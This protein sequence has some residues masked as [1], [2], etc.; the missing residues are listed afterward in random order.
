MSTKDNTG[1]DE[2]DSTTYDEESIE[3]ES[4]H[5]DRVS[6][7]VGA[8]N[9]DEFESWNRERQYSENI[10]NG[11]PYYNSPGYISP[12]K[13]HSPS[14]L[15]QCHRKLFYDNQ[16]TPS[17][18]GMPT[19]VFFFGNKFEDEMALPFLEDTANDLHSNNYIRQDMYINY[20]VEVDD[21]ELL[22]KGETDPVIADTE[23]APLVV[24]EIKTTG[25]IDNKKGEDATPS[26]RHKAQLH[27]Y[28]A[29][30]DKQYDREIEKGIIVYAERD[31]LEMVVFEIDFDEDFWEKTV[32]DWAT[33][34]T[35]FRLD[36]E[37]PP[38][39]PEEPSW[40]CKYC[41]YRERCGQNNDNEWEDTGINGFVPLVEYPDTEVVDYIDSEADNNAKLTP[42]LAYQHPDL[43]D[44]YDVFDW[45]CDHCDSSFDWNHFDWDGDNMNPP[46]CPDCADEHGNLPLRGPV[47]AEQLSK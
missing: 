1:A 25:Y 40:E 47:P 21:V 9:P 18:S 43:T 37:L 6:D 41:D 42:T 22:I 11:K 3:T 35:E 27:A 10:K 34:Q 19:G 36:D 31:S 29:G 20:E 23:G 46:T 14:K 39:D 7:I 4:E 17:E 33:D 16:N 13:K 28:M 44:D 38:A 32:L 5:N 26:R 30:L 45:E 2:N 24:T 15:L 12:E 8:I